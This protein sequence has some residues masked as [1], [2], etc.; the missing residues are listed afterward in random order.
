MSR[1]EMRIPLNCKMNSKQM[2]DFLSQLE[3]TNFNYS[4]RI[5]CTVEIP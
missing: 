3:K 5:D 1:I 4:L 2:R